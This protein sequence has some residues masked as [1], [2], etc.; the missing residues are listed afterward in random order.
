MADP[1]QATQT[2]VT[3]E[4]DEPAP[5]STA[6]EKLLLKFSS[7]KN[8]CII[9]HFQWVRDPS[10]ASLGLTAEVRVLLFEEIL[11]FSLAVAWM[12]LFAFVTRGSSNQDSWSHQ[13]KQVKVGAGTTAFDNLILLMTSDHFFY[14]IDSLKARHP[15][16]FH[17]RGEN[18][19]RV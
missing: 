17:S 6:I 16:I 12:P 9:S 1:A 18:Y 11:P 2:L 14:R 10:M 15:S 13:S 7:L 4:R 3:G 8:T 5:L 19:T